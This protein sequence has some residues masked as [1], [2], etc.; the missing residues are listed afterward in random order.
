MEKISNISD[1]LAWAMTHANFKSQKDLERASGIPQP[2]INRILNKPGKK[3]PE[4]ETVRLLADACG[5]SFLWLNEGSGSPMRSGEGL[6]DEIGSVTDRVTDVDMQFGSRLKAAREAAGMSQ[7]DIAVQMGITPQGVHKWESGAST[8]RFDR[9]YRL[10]SAL[11][12]PV[13]KLLPD[14][15]LEIVSFDPTQMRIHS[16]A[17]RIAILS[18]E[19]QRAIAIILEVSLN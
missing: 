2:T 5:V 19:K 9:L 6:G 18:P 10:A 1:R 12:I 7:T 4:S 11:G 15:P 3:G 14:D 8:P 16:L 17:A 13:S